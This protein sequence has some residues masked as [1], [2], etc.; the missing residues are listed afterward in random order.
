[1]AQST[2]VTRASRRPG[3]RVRERR[4]GGATWVRRLSDPSG[5]E[6]AD[7]EARYA[8]FL[9]DAGPP[10]TYRMGPDGTMQEIT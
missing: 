2:F 4:P 1:M 6:Q 10:R 8:A 9:R 3:R 5:Q 7:R